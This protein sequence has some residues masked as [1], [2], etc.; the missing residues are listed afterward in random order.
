MDRAAARS[1][2]FFARNPLLPVLANTNDSGPC[3]FPLSS[4][5]RKS[6]IHPACNPTTSRADCR[7]GS[8]VGQ[9]RQGATLKIYKGGSRGIRTTEKD[10]VNEDLLTFI[11]R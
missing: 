6:P 2:V 7:P 11:G 8:A 9:A 10:Q 5:L 3:P 4:T 1:N